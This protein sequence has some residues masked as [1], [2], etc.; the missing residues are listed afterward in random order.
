MKL[1]LPAA[2]VVVVSLVTVLDVSAAGNRR[3]A[4]SAPSSLDLQLSG[5]FRMAPA[6]VC[7]T[8]R[9]DSHADNRVLRVEL[10]S[11][12]YYRASEIQLDG[13]EAPRMHQILW[14]D[15]PAGHYR[16]AAVLLGTRGA[17]ATTEREFDVIGPPR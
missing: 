9:I 11:P 4:P 6:R 14:G 17:R 3:R 7:S 12:D 13:A 5:H 10:D 1:C 16:V 15:L 2:L 8:V